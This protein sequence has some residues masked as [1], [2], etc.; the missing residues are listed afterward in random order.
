MLE[1]VGG[2]DTEEE[3]HGLRDGRTDKV[4][5]LEGETGAVLERSS[6]LVGTLV[7]DRGEERV[8][9]VPVSI[10][11]LN[12]VNSGSD[13]TLGG[14]N[15]CGLEL[16]NVVE[17]HLLGLG[18]TLVVGNVGRSLDIVWPTALLSSSNVSKT[19][20]RSKARGLAS[21]VGKLDGDLLVLGVG[22]LNELCEGLN[23]GVFPETTVLGGD[24]ALREDSS[25][26]NDNE[27]GSAGQ[28]TTEMGHVPG[29]DLSVLGGVLAK[30][31]EHYAVLESGTTD[32]EGLEER[33]NG[34][35]VG[36]GVH[37]SS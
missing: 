21:S 18:V 26:L 30:R 28:D 13:G 34:I 15:P 27:T 7:G 1:A 33:R 23:L 3:G 24:T 10:V 19:Q 14:S 22:E 16:L 36:L 6:V 8:E 12:N 31:R 9:K 2:G 4:D 25:G 5:N 17:G 37:S 35:A 20:P 29:S 32:G 11:D